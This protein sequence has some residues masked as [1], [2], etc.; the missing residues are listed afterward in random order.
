[1]SLPWL[2]SGHQHVPRP[3]SCAP[4]WRWYKESSNCSF[5]LLLSLWSPS[6]FCWRFCFDEEND[7]DAFYNFI[8]VIFCFKVLMWRFK[9]AFVDSNVAFNTLNSD[10]CSNTA[11]MGFSFSS[12][13]C[14]RKEIFC[15]FD[16]GFLSIPTVIGA[17]RVSAPNMP[18]GICM[19]LRQVV[20]MPSGYE[21]HQWTTLIDTIEFAHTCW[22]NPTGIALPRDWLRTNDLQCEICL[23]S[24][25]MIVKTMRLTV[26]NML[27]WSSGRFSNLISICGRC[28][29][30][31]CRPFF[32]CR[33][34][35]LLLWRKWR[36]QT[37]WGL[38]RFCSEHDGWACWQII[39][40]V[41]RTYIYI[42]I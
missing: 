18:W 11:S 23:R 20:E 14:T 2:L 6:C 16:N 9:V 21:F 12:N 42:Y 32:R 3:Q 37:P 8:V 22:T 7:V 13:F 24:L 19:F 30:R 40:S 39:R 1:M 25:N 27:R 5:R 31:S 29:F 41:L 10:A 34:L 17:V 36:V 38:R 28:V 26:T 35:R 33:F 4:S 15:P